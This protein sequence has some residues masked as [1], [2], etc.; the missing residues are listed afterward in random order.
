MAELRFHRDESIP[1]PDAIAGALRRAG[2]DVTTTQDANLRTTD[3]ASQMTFA[4]NSERVMVTCDS[5]FLKLAMSVADHSGI[6]FYAQ[7]SRHVGHVIEWLSLMYGVLDA[8]DMRGKIEF[9]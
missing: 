6:V 1:M 3:D 8:E 5:D 2:I 7:Q 4:R 9:I